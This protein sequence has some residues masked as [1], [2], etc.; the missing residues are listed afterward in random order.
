MFKS[1]AVAKA[2]EADPSKLDLKGE[3]REITVLFSDIR[4]FTSFSEGHPA[5]QVVRLLNE[6]FAAVVPVVESHGG[7]LNQYLGDGLMVLFG[8]PSLQ[9]DHALRAV[10]AAVEMVDRVHAMHDRWRRL[11]A[12]KFR[13]GVGV[14]TGGAVIGTIGSP[15]R[16]DYTAIGDTVNTA[17]RIESGNKEL[18]TE[19]LLSEKTVEALPEDTRGRVIARSRLH[20]LTVKGKTES[21]VVFSMETNAEYDGDDRESFDKPTDE[22]EPP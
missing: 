5:E 9:D 10:N 6:Y 22:G 19:I 12:N 20:R 14:H 1:E 21:L 3:Q 15:R 13:I 16:I 18:G 7:V 2:L 11:G 8:A 17:S 4:N